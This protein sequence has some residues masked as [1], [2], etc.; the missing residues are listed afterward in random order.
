MIDLAAIFGP[1]PVATSPGV[2]PASRPTAGDR[3]AATV[4]AAGSPTATQ[5]ASPEPAPAPFADWVL[6]PDVSG[7]LAWEAPELPEA[8]RWWA[9]S[10]FDD[11]PQIPTPCP[12][13]GLAE[14]W[15]DCAGR[16]RCP[17]CDPPTATIRLLEQAEGIR[18]RLGIPTPAGAAQWLADLRRL[19]NHPVRALFAGLRS[20]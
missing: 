14:M 7:R 1:D 9:D 17:H 2:H 5:A 12:E 10:S 15:Q 16:E 20:G 6:R 8:V 3:G 19:A 18:Q 11:L 13:C 4:D